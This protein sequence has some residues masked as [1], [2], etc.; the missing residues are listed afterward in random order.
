NRGCGPAVDE[1]GAEL[2]GDR[3][4]GFGACPDPPTDTVA[5][6]EHDDRKTFPCEFVRSCKAGCA[7]TYHDD[8]DGCPR[9]AVSRLQN[10]AWC[11]LRPRDS[12][13]VRPGLTPGATFA[14]SRF[15]A[16]SRWKLDVDGFDAVR[17]AV[18][19]PA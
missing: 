5:C 4:I 13:A 17:V 1:L 14:T 12:Q 9:H 2:D 7:R 8:V 10:E 6:L 19:E 3:Q 16:C 15:R 11:G 18:R